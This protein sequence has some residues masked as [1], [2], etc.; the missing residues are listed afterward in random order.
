MIS[1]TKVCSSGPLGWKMFPEA[2]AE[3]VVIVG[4]LG[5]DEILHGE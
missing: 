5:T 4:F 1:E 2:F 3:L